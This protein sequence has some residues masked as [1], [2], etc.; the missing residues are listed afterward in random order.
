[1]PTG[2]AGLDEILLGGLVRDRVYLVR[3]AP[4]TGKTTLGMGFLLEGAARGERCLLLSNAE[5]LGE[6]RALASAHGWDLSGV[7]VVPWEES[8]GK[9]GTEYTIFSPAEVELETTLAHLFEEV[10]R[11]E[12]QRLVVDSLSAL[13]IPAGDPALYRRQVQSLRAFLRERDCTTLLVED[14]V[15][16]TGTGTVVHGILHVE[17]TPGRYGR[18]RRTLRVVKMRGSDFVTGRHD[19]EIRRG[20]VLVFP[21]LIASAHAR[22][23][24]G[25]PVSSGCAELD[26]LTG[27]GICRGTSTLLLGPAG[28]GKSTVAALYAGAAA[29]RGER[30]D[31]YLFDEAP[32][33]WARRCTGLGIDVASHL[34]SGRLRLTHLD[35]AEV[36]I[37]EFSHRVVGAVE[38]GGARVIVIDTLNGFLHAMAGEGMLLLHLRELLSYLAQRG[39][40]TLLVMSQQGLVDPERASPMDVSYI[41][42]NVVAFRYYE[43]G[44][45]VQRAISMLKRRA[46]PHERTI[47]EFSTE[48][49]RVSVG[50]PLEHVQGVLDQ[51]TVTFLGSPPEGA[52]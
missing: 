26:A 41:A 46:G 45:A 1:M 50:A 12:P 4:G 34:D 36:S 20:G 42:D 51:G 37:G 3:G 48:A 16:G 33:L 29:E 35:P 6:V 39:V 7:D 24:G 8:S 32:E 47:R 40:L 30:A 28:T 25:E 10:A 49:G 19:L 13:R 11:R 44:G 38:E 27:G 31:L 14:A 5:T 18:D 17:Q 52:A 21:R 22:A 43:T 9:P 2:V 23:P 15:D